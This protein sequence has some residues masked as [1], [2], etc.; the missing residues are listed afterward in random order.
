MH[1]TVEAAVV[2][3]ARVSD[4]QVLGVT[5]L[6]RLKGESGA[7][8][9]NHMESYLSAPRGKPFGDFASRGIL[10]GL[11]SACVTTIHTVVRNRVDDVAIGC[12]L[13]VCS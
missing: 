11:S 2:F 9:Q 7:S 6:A 3:P 1:Q 12:Y 5:L 13:Q 10:L 4:V 8:K